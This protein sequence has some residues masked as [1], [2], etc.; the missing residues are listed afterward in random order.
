MQARVAV[1]RVFGTKDQYGDERRTRPRGLPLVFDHFPEAGACVRVDMG[2][3]PRDVVLAERMRRAIGRAGLGA[4]FGGRSG[5][6]S[7]PE[8][9]NRE[10]EKSTEVELFGDFNWY[11]TLVLERTLE[12][13]Q[14]AGGRADFL[15]PDEFRELE[16]TMPAYAAP[17]LDVVTSIIAT[18]VDPHVFGSLLLDDRI[19]LFGDGKRPSGIPVFSLSASGAVWRGQAEADLLSQRI[20]LLRAVN[21]SAVTTHGWLDGV[22]H[23]RVQALRESDPWKRFLWSFLALEVLTNKLFDARRDAVLGRLRLLTDGGTAAAGNPPIE[24]LAWAPERAPLRSRFALVASELFPASAREDVGKFA[25]AKSGRDRLAH[26]QIRDAAELPTAITA[27]LLEKYFT[28]AAK[29]L[30]LGL[31]PQRSWED[32]AGYH[33]VD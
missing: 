32:L 6:S 20:E 8:Q 30:L 23:W 26:G 11:V 15:L 27:D 31:D 33:P 4:L 10:F 3:V 12:V 29:T 5:T 24:E 19:H 7:G 16:R 9:I 13:T 1:V 2:P 22:A 17:A 14:S 28:G 21:T 25:S 18:I